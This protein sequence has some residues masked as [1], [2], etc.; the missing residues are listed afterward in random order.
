[1]RLSFASA[2]ADTIRHHA[3]ADH[4][5]EAC[6]LLLGQPG[7]VLEAHP[8]RNVADRPERH[9]EID[10]ALLLRLHREAR[11]R[12]LSVLGHYHSHPNGQLAPSR[13]DAARALENGQIWVIAANGALAAWLATAPSRFTPVELEIG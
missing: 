12:G 10:P 8:A 3:A 2:A 6:G 5:L 11:G 1:M 13:R 7:A 9:F 4:P